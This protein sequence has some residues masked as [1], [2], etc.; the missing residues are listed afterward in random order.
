VVPR[1]R[2]P[3]RQEARA[4]RDVLRP[5]RR[6]LLTPASCLDEHGGLDLGTFRG[7]DI[8]SIHKAA[9][10]AIE[11]L[12][13]RLAPAGRLDR[14][15]LVVEFTGATPKLPRPTLVV[16]RWLPTGFE[17]HAGAIERRG[18]TRIRSVVLPPALRTGDVEVYVYQV[19]GEAR[20][21]GTGRDAAL[22]YVPWRRGAYW[23]LACRPAECFVIA[24]A[25]VLAL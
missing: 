18:M 1:R 14:L 13:A 25:R 15:D 3:R 19:D 8:G 4:G 7:I 24:A 17:A 23:A 22:E 12:R 16:A 6:D 10:A 2:L 21:L 20:R 11:Q 9:R 5:A